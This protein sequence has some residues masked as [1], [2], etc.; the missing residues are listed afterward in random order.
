SIQQ[1]YPAHYRCHRGK[2]D[3]GR[4]LTLGDWQK[5]TRCKKCDLIHRLLQAQTPGRLLDFGCGAGDFL[6]C[7]QALGWAVTGL[8]MAQSAV[9]RIREQYGLPAHL[10]TL[11]HPLLT[12]ASFEM[13]TM[14]QS[15]EHVY[16]PLDVLH[17]A[18]RLLTR[19][20]RLLVAVPNFDSQA[21]R[22]FG[23][24]W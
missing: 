6:L 13:I 17:A 18:Y 7:M 12:A 20:G 24:A 19:P 10:G 11:P 5:A 21:S 4:T 23:A 1:F 9:T 22:W 2:E 16:Q 15:L 3:V 14:R 8:D